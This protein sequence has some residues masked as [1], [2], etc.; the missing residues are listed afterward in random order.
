M[1]AHGS[2]ND[3]CDYVSGSNRSLSFEQ[4]VPLQ[5]RTINKDDVCVSWI[6]EYNNTMG[7][8]VPSLMHNAMAR[9]EWAYISRVA[10]QKNKNVLSNN[11]L[12]DYY[13]NLY[14]KMNSQDQYSDE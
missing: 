7:A 4:F 2:L 13:L 9:Y 10:F 14:S 11:F 8:M 6:G 3:W 12:D 1:Y 5:T